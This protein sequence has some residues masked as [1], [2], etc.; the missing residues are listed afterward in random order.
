MSFEE[1]ITDLF[2]VKLPLSTSALTLLT[3]SSVVG[4]GGEGVKPD[5][6][7]KLEISYENVKPY[8]LLHIHHRFTRACCFHLQGRKRRTLQVLI[9]TE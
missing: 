7:L 3:G 2:S 5:T 1:S 9:N 4:L 6:L 8:F